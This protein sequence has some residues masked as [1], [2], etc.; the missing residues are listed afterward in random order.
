MRRSLG[1]N[2]G[3][4]LHADAIITGRVNL[5]LALGQNG[6]PFATIDAAA[7][8][9]DHR[10]ETGDLAMPVKPGGKYRIAGI[11]SANPRFMSARHL[12]KL[13]RFKPGQTWQR[14]KIDDFR[15]A[16]IATGLVAS[17]TVTPR[18]TKAPTAGQPGDVNLDV[19][20]AKAKEHTISAA[21]GYDTAEGFRLETTWE[22]RNEFPPEGSLRLRAIAGTEEQLAGVTFR[23]NNFVGRD[24]ALTADLYAE[25]ANLTAFSARKLDFAVS[26]ERLSTLIFQKPWTW[27]VGV[28]TVAS[29]EREGEPNGSVLG[30][31]DTATI[32][33]NIPRTNYLTVALPLR[34]AY[35][36][37]DSLLDPKHGWRVA[38]RVSP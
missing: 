23:R 2:T 36:G 32:N 28:E 16:V 25:N 27:A 12:A 14:S 17:V 11:T 31:S 33:Y 13:A 6:Y 7:L 3:D 22:N 30:N 35:D 18:E 38:L 15:E 21:V 29:A 5:D 34:V 10:R 24:R 4:P 8:V 26:Y 20:M 9:V 19:A 1:I 37:S